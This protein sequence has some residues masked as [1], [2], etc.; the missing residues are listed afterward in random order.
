LERPDVLL[1]HG[2]DVES[3][4][5]LVAGQ[6]LDAELALARHIDGNTGFYLAS[7]REDAEFFALRRGAGKVLTYE[8]AMETFQEPLIG[9]AA[10]G[11]IP[12]GPSSPYFK[13][14]ELFV[15]LSLFSLFNELLGGA[16]SVRG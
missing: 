15:P 7:E 12:R 3:A 13:G 9:G 8:L 16:I 11:P 1:Y 2:T 10:Y 6:S 4:A 5:A 14:Q